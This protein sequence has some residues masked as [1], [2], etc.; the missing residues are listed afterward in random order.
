MGIYADLLAGGAF[1][2]SPRVGLHRSSA[3][4]VKAQISLV[5]PL[6]STAHALVNEVATIPE[7]TDA[8]ATDTYTLTLTFYGKLAGTVYT[9]AAIAYDAVAS[10][11]AAAIVTAG[12]T[13]GHITAAMGGSAGLDDGTVMLTF[14]GATVAGVPCVVTLTPTGFTASGPITRAPGSPGRKAL[15]ALYELNVVAGTVHVVP[16]APA[17]WTRPA[18]NGQSRPRYDLIKKLAI[19]A[20][21]E[22]GTPH[23]YEAVKA[24]YPGL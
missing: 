10:T 5:D 9:T 24:L 16:A 21:N 3:E 6:L 15:Q 17:D 20:S 13:E 18:S 4:Q 19:E 7:Q 14:S 2:N 23:V 12:A 8:G 22:D 1:G 11:I